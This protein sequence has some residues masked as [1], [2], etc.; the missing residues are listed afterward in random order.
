MDRIHSQVLFRISFSSL[1]FKN[2]KIK[3]HKTII[4]PVVL[5]GYKTLSLTLWKAGENC[6][7]VSWYASPNIDR[8]FKSSWMEWMEDVARVG[9]M[10]NV[11]IILIGIYMC[12][13]EDD[14]RKELREVGWGGVRWMHLT[15]VRD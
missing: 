13:W 6:I 9:D 2:L 8:V 7:M 5:Y 11:H 12:R 15:Q 4:L 1:L 3:K 10:N 14:V